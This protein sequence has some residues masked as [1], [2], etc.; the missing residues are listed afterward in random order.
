MVVVETIVLSNNDRLD[1]KKLNPI[2]TAFFVA[3]F[4]SKEPNLVY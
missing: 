2:R 1:W 4:T 3:E